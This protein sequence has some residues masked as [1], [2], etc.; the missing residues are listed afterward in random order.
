M[1]SDQKKKKQQADTSNQTDGR[2]AGLSM[3]DWN[4][5]TSAYAKYAEQEANRYMDQAQKVYAKMPEYIQ[6]ADQVM[7]ELPSYVPNLANP[8]FTKKMSR[9]ATD[10]TLHLIKLYQMFGR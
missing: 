10:A 7:Q 2:P 3:D 8:H 1:P 6:T 4:K 5:I 9:K